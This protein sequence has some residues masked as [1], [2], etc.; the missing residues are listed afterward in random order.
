MFFIWVGEVFIGLIV[1]VI[2]EDKYKLIIYFCGAI[3][4]F[5]ALIF[6]SW[7]EIKAWFSGRASFKTAVKSFI[8]VPATNSWKTK[9]EIL[10]IIKKSSVVQNKSPRRNQP[11]RTIQDDLMSSLITGPSGEIQYMHQ[12]EKDASIGILQKIVGKHPSAKNGDK[13][14][15]EIIEFELSQMV[16]EI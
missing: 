5:G 3:I 16:L 7:P 6:L 8:K 1:T 13:F 4:A 2:M 14:S 12:Y 9:N 10:K 15:I 11:A